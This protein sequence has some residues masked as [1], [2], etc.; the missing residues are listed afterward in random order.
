MFAHVS[1]H[2]ILPKRL[3]SFLTMTAFVEN[4]HHIKAVA[5]TKGERDIR[6]CRPNRKRHE[7]SRNGYDPWKLHL[8][9]SHNG[10]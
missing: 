10:R 8:S 3:D 7:R 4:L 1:L 5:N 6:H 9:G 2:G